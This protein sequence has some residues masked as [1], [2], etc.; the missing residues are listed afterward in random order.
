MSDILKT[1]LRFIVLIWILMAAW[2]YLLH[3]PWHWVMY[4]VMGFELLL[5]IIT[6]AMELQA[7]DVQGA[8]GWMGFAFVIL[9]IHLAWILGFARLLLWGYQEFWV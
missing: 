2:V 4:V 7:K 3:F 9:N 6:L 5:A 8:S 1:M